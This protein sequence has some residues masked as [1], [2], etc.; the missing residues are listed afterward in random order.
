MSHKSHKIDTLVA[1]FKGQDMEAHYLAY[2][3]CFNRQLY[4][5]A[6]EVLECIWLPQRQGPEGAFYKGLIQLAG[7]FVHLQKNRLGPGASLLKL[8]QTNLARYPATHRRLDTARLLQRIAEWL[9]Q[10]DGSSAVTNPLAPA[11]GP[12]LQLQKPAAD[13]AP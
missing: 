1:P 4:F 2:F 5:E 11:T 12:K 7:A 8:A 6:H 9:R 10:L 3:E 13:S